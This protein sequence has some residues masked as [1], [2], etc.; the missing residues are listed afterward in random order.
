M[1]VAGSLVKT[2]GSQFP[3]GYFGSRTRLITFSATWNT[4]FSRTLPFRHLV[5]T[6]E[7]SADPFLRAVMLFISLLAAPKTLGASLLANFV[8]IFVGF[9]RSLLCLHKCSQLNLLL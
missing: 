8:P 5:K 6:L 3:N 7:L 1:G 4:L 2:F 9:V